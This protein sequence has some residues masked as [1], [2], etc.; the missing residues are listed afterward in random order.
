MDESTEAAPS[1]S[2]AA[3]IGRPPL[4]ERR[5]AATRLEIAHEALRLFARQGVA[6]TTVDEI[7]DAAGISKRTLWRYF[8][9]K[10]SCVRPLLSAGIDALVLAMREAPPGLSLLDALRRVS[11]VNGL[12]PGYSESVLALARLIGTEPGLRAEWLRAHHDTEALLA[13][14][15]ADRSDLAAGSMRPRVHAAIVNVAMRVAIE[16]YAADPAGYSSLDEA[17]TSAVRIAAA[18]LRG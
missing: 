5:K 3:R 9:T 18:G 6:A 8:P 4:T 14:V 16:E 1:A 11:Q 7:A 10:E 15:I 17:I 2:A 12:A 13:D